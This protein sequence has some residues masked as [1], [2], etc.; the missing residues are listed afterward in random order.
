MLIDKVIYKITLSILLS[1]GVAITR[2]T[3]IEY[4]WWRSNH[5]KNF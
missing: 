3:F 4:R 2:N 5:Q 1:A